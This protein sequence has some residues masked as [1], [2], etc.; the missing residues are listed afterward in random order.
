MA[1]DG[2]GHIVADLDLAAQDAD[3]ARRCP[4]LA[5]RRPEAYALA[6]E[7]HV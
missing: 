3:P 2:E 1:P 6:E 5:N 4:S 7:A